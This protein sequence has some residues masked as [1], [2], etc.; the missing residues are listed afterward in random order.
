MNITK[1]HYKVIIFTCT[2]I[3]CVTMLFAVQRIIKI[4][5]PVTHIQYLFYTLL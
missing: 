3:S 1:Q 4:I 5:A 2:V